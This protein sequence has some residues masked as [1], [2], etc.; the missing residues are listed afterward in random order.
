MRLG[1]ASVTGAVRFAE[2]LSRPLQPRLRA[3]GSGSGGAC[4][5]SHL[6]RPIVTDPAAVL[7]RSERRGQGVAS[8][9]T[10]RA[11]R[12]PRVSAYAARRCVCDRRYALLRGARQAVAAPPLRIVLRVGQRLRAL[13]PAESNRGRPGAGG[14]GERRRGRGVILTS[15]GCRQTASALRVCGS[16]VRGWPAPWPRLLALASGPDRP[17]AYNQPHTQSPTLGRIG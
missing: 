7:L 12:P 15:R 3:S 1:G 9:R 4:A 5:P 6:P 17:C 10:G 11:G 8:T 2:A 14:T 13:S 16:A